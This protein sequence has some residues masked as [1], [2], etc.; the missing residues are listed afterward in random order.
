MSNIF[1]DYKSGDIDPSSMKPSFKV[2][3][4]IDKKFLILGMKK[5]EG[6]SKFSDDPVI[7]VN[8]MGVDGD[9]FVF[10]VSSQK[11]LF[12]KITYLMGLVNAGNKDVYASTTFLIKRTATKDGES[13]YY[14]IVDVTE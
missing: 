6:K 8:A 3:E 10:F 14:D 1:G 5:L 2:S 9:E 7:L 12:D 13:F 4:I 11:V